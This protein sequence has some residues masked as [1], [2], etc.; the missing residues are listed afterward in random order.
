MKPLPAGARVTLRRDVTEI[1]ASWRRVTPKGAPMRVSREL[2]HKDSEESMLIATMDEVSPDEYLA[3][4]RATPPVVQ[5]ADTRTT[6]VSSPTLL[7]LEITRQLGLLMGHRAGGIPL[8]WAFLLNELS[9]QGSDAFALGI[10]ANAAAMTA[11]VR[12]SSARVRAG[13]CDEM[14]AFAVFEVDHDVVA[15]GS[16]SFRC[17]PRRTYSALRRR[18][19]R[20]PHPRPSNGALAEVSV[21]GLDLQAHLGWPSANRLIF[22]HEVDHVPGLLF[23]QAG[24]EAHEHLTG[25]PPQEVALECPRFAEIGEVVSISARR[26]GH[27]VSTAADQAHERVA[28]VRCA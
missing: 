25:T 2:V 9:F 1:T 5:A 8:D 14:T 21:H 24:I 13:R 15:E 27:Q 12:I 22:D 3:R 20:A 17:V 19:L 18:Q 7:G 6:A 23:A 28:Q 11:S 4:L 26:S 10:A 16:G